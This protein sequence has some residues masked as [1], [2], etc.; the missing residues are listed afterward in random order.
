MIYIALF[1][2][3]LKYCIYKELKSQ[4]SIILILYIGEMYYAHYLKCV[5][6]YYNCI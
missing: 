1:V 3:T 4:K 6:G 5:I 2:S